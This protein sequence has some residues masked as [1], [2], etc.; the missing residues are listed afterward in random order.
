MSRGVSALPELSPARQ[1]QRRL[2]TVS[3]FEQ[4]VADVVAVGNSE[5]FE[6]SIR[7]LALTMQLR[8]EDE[9]ARSTCSQ[10]GR[11]AVVALRLD[12]ATSL[13]LYACEEHESFQ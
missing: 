2:L 5:G 4:A 8:L 12:D 6:V 13:T 9:L 7:Q 10:C 3:E 11:R 1:L